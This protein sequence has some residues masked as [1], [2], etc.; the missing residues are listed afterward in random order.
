MGCAAGLFRSDGARYIIL[1][2]SA[3]VACQ[4]RA[5]FRVLVA[6]R[7]LQYPDRNRW[8]RP[9][10]DTAGAL[11][12]RPDTQALT[13]SP[14]PLGC[15]RLSEIRRAWSRRL[16]FFMHSSILSTVMATPLLLACGA[17]IPPPTQP[18]ADAESA[19]RSAR[20]LGAEQEPVAQLSLKLADDQ[21][22]EARKA[23]TAGDNERAKS[24]LIRAKADAELAVAQ[25][26]E[27]GARADKQ[28]AVEDSAAQKA[29]N[30]GQGAVK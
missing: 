18:M 14:R 30:V 8:N 23:M 22:A 24:L 1:M 15:W 20:E 13:V 28:E 3:R 10:N 12:G 17:S 6:A 16:E 7:N 29:T 27:K 21:I 5:F 11:R 4:F 25:A 19:Q 2:A 9:P 26:K